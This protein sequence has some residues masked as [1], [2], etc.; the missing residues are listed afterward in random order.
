M[1]SQVAIGTFMLSLNFCI[2]CGR[3]FFLSASSAFQSVG[4][5]SLYSDVDFM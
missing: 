2:F 1:D 5:G 3:R 4:L